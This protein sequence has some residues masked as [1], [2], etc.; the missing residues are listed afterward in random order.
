LLPKQYEFYQANEFEVMYS[1]AFGAGKS[2]ALCYKL[3]RHALIPGN[4]V[5]LCRE[6]FTA[7][8]HSTLR[9]LLKDESGL[10]PVLP[11][12][13]YDH[14]K[15]EH[16]IRIHGGGEIFYF[17]L[18]EAQKF[19]SLNFGAVGIDEVVELDEEKYNMLAGR[20]RNTIDPHRQ[21]FSATNPGSHLH[22]LYRRFFTDQSPARRVIQTSSLD[23]FYLP[24][25]YNALLKS[26]TGQT[27]RRYV[28]GK[29]G[30]FEGLVYDTFDDTPGTGHIRHRDFDEFRDFYVGCDAGYAHPSASVLIGEDQSNRLHVCAVYYERRATHDDHV[31]GTAAFRA[32]M[33]KMRHISGVYVDPSAAA[34]AEAMRR[35]GFVTLE[36]DNDVEPGI[37]AVRDMLRRDEH[38]IPSLTIEPGLAPLVMEFGSYRLDKPRGAADYKEKPVKEFDDLMD[39]MRYVVY[40]RWKVGRSDG[41]PAIRARRAIKLDSGERRKLLL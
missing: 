27:Y 3:L 38:G 18:D 25:D 11:E 24:D 9:T 32:M 6:T 5:G 4:F 14:N 7:L 34:L 30:A 17:G 2:R 8:R 31:K 36:T 29:W 22:Y 13:T 40:G 16:I 33:P 41:F 19:G 28:E 21:I 39:A 10:P 35:A 15:S 20:C 1:G 12:G 26:F 37:H 23:N